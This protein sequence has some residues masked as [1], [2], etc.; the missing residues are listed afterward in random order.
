M[1]RPFVVLWLATLLF[2]LGFQLLLP[3]IPLYGVG[4][5]AGQPALLAMTA[6]RVPPGER[7][8]A[9]GT[10]YTAWEL[11]ISGGSIVLGLCATR[12]GYT[13]TWWIAAAIAGMGALAALY[14]GGRPRG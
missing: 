4:F 11:G 12:L 2:Y 1:R 7:G 8:R 3:V 9:M 6:D 13:A 5:G 14:P 10:L